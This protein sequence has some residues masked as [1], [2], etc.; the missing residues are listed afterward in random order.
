MP[1]TVVCPNR[2]KGRC[3]GCPHRRP[4]APG[5]DCILDEDDELYTLNPPECRDD[6]LPVEELEDE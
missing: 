6:C 5:K 1:E 2:D 3:D 4:H